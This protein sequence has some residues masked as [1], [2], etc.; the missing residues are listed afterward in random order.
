MGLVG[1]QERQHKEM[2]ALLS[3]HNENA[4]ASL[5][6]HCKGT[7]MAWSLEKE[8]GSSGSEFLNGEGLWGDRTW[9]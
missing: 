8:K 1:C 7:Q 6:Y 2:M 3:C 4:S 9:Q 5:L